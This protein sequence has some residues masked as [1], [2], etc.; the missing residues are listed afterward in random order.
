MSS[1]P[2]PDDWSA[3]GIDPTASVEAVRAAYRTR[4]RTV[5]PE[6]D[7]DGFQRLRSA[8]ETI[9]ASYAPT[10]SASAPAKDIGIDRFITILAARRAAGDEAG[11]IA[12][13]DA[14][15][16]AHTPGSADSEAIENALLDHVALERTLSPALF[17]HL[18]AHYDWRD[19]QGH[20]ARRD[21]EHHAVILDRIA[22]EDFFTAFGAFAR[23]PEGRLEALVLAPYDQTL[24]SLGAEGIGPEQRAEIRDIFDQFLAHGALLIGRLDGGTLALLRE[25]VEGPALVGD[26]VVRTAGSPGRAERAAPPV[27]VTDTVSPKAKRKIRLGVLAIIGAVVLGKVFYKSDHIPAGGNDTAIAAEAALP[28]LKNPQVPWVDMVREPDGVRVDWAPVMRMR[29][30]IKDLRVGYNDEKPTTVFPLPQFDAP[31][32]FIAPP[33]MTA[34]TLRMR[35]TDGVWSEVRRYPIP[36]EKE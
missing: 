23:S 16:A 18:V 20:A 28:L 4:L 27:S 36:R 8:Y 3:L 19:V 10:G 33:E 14:T 6:T 13:V 17:L 15:R 22:A 1:T 9:L 29:H 2:T 21:P 30:A 26:P 24:A 31:I 32:G 12:L 5:G 35:T 34:I 7:P 25:A 11:A